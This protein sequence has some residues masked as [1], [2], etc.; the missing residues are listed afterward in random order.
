MPPEQYWWALAALAAGTFLA[1]FM[2]KPRK[3][4]IVEK[5]VEP[6]NETVTDSLYDTKVA[7][8]QEKNHP[9]LVQEI[10]ALARRLAAGGREITTDDIHAAMTLP[11]GVD[12]RILGTAFMPRKD[13]V[14]GPY[15]PTK[16]KAANSR[17]IP[18][19]TLREYVTE[20]N[21]A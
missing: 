20:E 3:V 6:E 8:E 2:P 7:P 21:A 13:W 17:P 10:R 15:R 5:I 16:R 19:W 18:S 12:P 14:K 4:I 9:E 11:S 1:V